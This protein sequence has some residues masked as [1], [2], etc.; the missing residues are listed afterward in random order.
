MENKISTDIKEIKSL[1]LDLKARV[2]DI[3]EM[4]SL[5]LDL[6]S[7]VADIEEMKSMTL[8]FHARLT[9]ATSQKEREDEKIDKLIELFDKKPIKSV[10]SSQPRDEKSKQE[11]KKRV[12][13]DQELKTLMCRDGIGTELWRD[14]FRDKEDDS[15]GLWPFPSKKEEVQKLMDEKYSKEDK[16][17]KDIS[18]FIKNAAGSNE[19]LIKRTVGFL[20]KNVKESGDQEQLEF[21][22]GFRDNDGSSYPENVKKY[23]KNNPH[24]AIKRSLNEKDNNK[25]PSAKKAS[26][27]KASTKTEI[28]SSD[29][30]HKNNNGSDDDSS[31]Q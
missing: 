15:V 5:L 17:K 21:L 3:E 12:P 22:K 10:K 30:E 4:K 25:K 8:D 20:W 29:S 26:A 14:I 9:D 28:E 13:I 24:L 11:I 16:S 19:Q 1:L 31:D 6:K 23:L 2:A 7:R 27:K 18:N